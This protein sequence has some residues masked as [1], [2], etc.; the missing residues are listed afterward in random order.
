M[1]SL[2]RMLRLR[3]HMF[4]LRWP[5]YCW[6]PCSSRRFGAGLVSNVRFLVLGLVVG[7]TAYG[8]SIYSAVG[9][10]IERSAVLLFDHDL[11][12]SFLRAYWYG[13]RN[14]PLLKRDG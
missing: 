2:L 4:F 9:G 3:W 10:W 8:M 7:A 12:F 14:E 6:R 13:S 1:Q 11:S 5:L